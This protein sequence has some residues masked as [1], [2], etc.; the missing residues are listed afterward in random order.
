MQLAN[1]TFYFVIFIILMGLMTGF[2][3]GRDGQKGQY[4]IIYWPASLGLLALSG[5]SFFLAPWLG[6]WILAVANFSLVAGITSLSLLFVSWRDAL[7]NRIKFLATIFVLGIFLAYLLLLQFGQAGD[8]IHLM[9]FA[10]GILSLWQLRELSLL[11]KQDDA[12][13]LRLLI[14][15]EYFQ[16]FV[17]VLRSIFLALQSDLEISTIYQED[18]F[19]FSL[20]VLSI[21]SIVVICILI[22]NFYLE[23][24]MG[25]HQKS[26]HAIESGMLDS[27]N[28]LSMVRDNETGNHIL[29]TKNYVQAIANRLR[30]VGLYKDELSTQA[31][32]NMTKA[33]PLHDIGKV[34]I[35]DDILKKNGP[36]TDDEWIVMKTHPFLGEEVLKAAKVEDVRHTQVLDAAIDIAGGHHECWDGSG[37]PRGLHGLDIPLAARIMSVADM[38]DALV[39]ERIYK[40][41]WS[42]EDACA[43]ISRLKGTRFDPAVVEAFLMECENFIRIAELYKD[44]K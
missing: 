17:R 8:R 1:Q 27:L 6:K 30:D 29:R 41:K 23:K 19:G 15:V 7:S 11:V 25:E 31:I 43:E 16:L 2:F 13:Q 22:T 18:I 10:L 34:G 24:L 40:E 28:A 33:A 38:Y 14:A 39:S 12:Y 44:E 20:R 4:K 42:H 3:W 5:F 26:A 37:Y 36:L 35:P 32:C 9:N 21:L